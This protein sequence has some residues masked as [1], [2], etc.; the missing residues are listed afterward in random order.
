MKNLTHTPGPWHCNVMG[1]AV[2]SGER[3]ERGNYPRS[4]QVFPFYATT[5]V[6]LDRHKADARLIAAAPE[7]LE[8]CQY[9]ALLDWAAAVIEEAR[10]DIYKGE[11][12]AL[13]LSTIDVVSLRNGAKHIRAAIAKAKG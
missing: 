10:N 8:A 7:L 3:D 5:G 1:S 9:G 13:T 11:S 4:E 6:H 2:Y 12:P